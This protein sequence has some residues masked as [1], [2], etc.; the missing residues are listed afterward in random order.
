MSERNAK[1]QK[2]YD[3]E[4]VSINKCREAIGLPLLVSRVRVCMRCR[5]EFASIEKRRCYSCLAISDSQRCFLN[6]RE[7]IYENG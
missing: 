6:G 5:K 4:L 7:I 1:T 2:A 3:M